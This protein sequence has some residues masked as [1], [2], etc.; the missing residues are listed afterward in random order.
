M[1]RKPKFKVRH[2]PTLG[3]L[4]RIG[5]PCHVDASIPMV[6]RFKSLAYGSLL[7]GFLSASTIALGATPV[8]QM[9]S[10]APTLSAFEAGLRSSYPDS[11]EEL[12]RAIAARRRH[13]QVKRQIFRMP[14][15]KR[16]DKHYGISAFRSHL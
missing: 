6:R 16:P 9:P 1:G 14:L 12:K 13:Q 5:G 3:A 10:A 4:D 2:H 11:A 7:P 8:A 15:S